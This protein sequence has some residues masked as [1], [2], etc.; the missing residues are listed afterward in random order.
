MNLLDKAR[1]IFIFIIIL[2]IFIF[3]S[4]F[5]QD[6]YKQFREISD[7]P[8]I[9][10]IDRK[11]RFERPEDIRNNHRA[12]ENNEPFPRRKTPAGE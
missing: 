3:C 11:R 12:F 2:S 4:L 7:R 5:I 1:N 10:R 6:S 8:G 9:R